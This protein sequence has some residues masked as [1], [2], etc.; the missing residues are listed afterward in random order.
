MFIV[1]RSQP[2]SQVMDSYIL[3]SQ[4]YNSVAATEWEAAALQVALQSS[5]VNC[6]FGNAVHV[7]AEDETFTQVVNSA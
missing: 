5:S 7:P 4:V 2:A 1:W 3:A 6:P